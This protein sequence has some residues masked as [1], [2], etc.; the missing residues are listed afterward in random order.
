MD[1][2]HGVVYEIPCEC[3]KIYI[4]ETGNKLKTRMQNH[5]SNVSC[6]TRSTALAIHSMDNDHNFNFDE[7]KIIQRES[8]MI[9]RRIHESAHITSNLPSSVNCVNNTI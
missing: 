6:K 1:Q 2:Q 7:T 9:N 5:Q 8:N 3:G 4:G